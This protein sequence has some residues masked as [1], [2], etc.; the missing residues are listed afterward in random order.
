MGEKQEAE[1]IGVSGN[2][3]KAAKEKWNYWNRDKGGPKHMGATIGLTGSH[4]NRVKKIQRINES[5]NRRPQSQK[6]HGGKLTLGGGNPWKGKRG[7]TLEMEVFGGRNQVEETKEAKKW[8]PLQRLT[9][10]DGKTGTRRE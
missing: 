7:K 1:T 10:Q 8:V 4:K 3:G 6:S 9:F 2:G 5:G